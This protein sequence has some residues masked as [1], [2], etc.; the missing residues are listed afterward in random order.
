MEHKSSA[1]ASRHNFPVGVISRPLPV[2]SL[3][4]ILCHHRH[5]LGNLS[6]P[7]DFHG[8]NKILLHEWLRTEAVLIT[9]LH[10]FYEVKPGTAVLRIFY[11]PF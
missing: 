6:F 10:L 1:K 2:L 3:L 11:K 7:A 4:P 9:V 8:I 5:I